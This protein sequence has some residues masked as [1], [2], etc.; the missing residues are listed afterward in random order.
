[1]ACP[2][3]AAPAVSSASVTDIINSERSETFVLTNNDTGDN[4]S[5][6]VKNSKCSPQKLIPSLSG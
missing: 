4:P 1:M 6:H 3:L 2:V 5:V